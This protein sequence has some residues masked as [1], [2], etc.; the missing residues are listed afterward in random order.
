MGLDRDRMRGAPG[1]T[2]GTGLVSRGAAETA[3]EL[4][5]SS[6]PPS[7]RFRVRPAPHLAALPFLGRPSLI[8]AVTQAVRAALV[9]LAAHRAR[10]VMTMFGIVV[11]VCGVLTINVLGQAQN[12]ALAAQ[13]AQLGTNLISISPGFAA[14]RGVSAGS[15]SKPTLTDRDVQLLQQQVPDVRA[16]TPLVTGTETLAAGDQT[17]GAAVTGAYPSIETV[18]SDA[19]RQ[20]AFFTWADESGRQP[21]AVLGQTVVGHLFPGRSP[22]G[23]NIRIG[24]VDFRVVGVLEPKGH[25]GQ[26][27]LDD[28]AIVPFSTAQERLFGQKVDSIVIQAT[29]TAQIPAV[30]AAATSTLE[31]SHHLPVGGRPDFVVQ[32]F[33]QVVDAAKQQTEL[34]T[35]VLTVVAGVAL[36]IGGF[37]VMN[38]M[39]ISV[40][41]RTAEI[42]LRLA[43]GARPGDVLLQFLVEALTV[44][45]IAGLIGLLLGVAGPVALRPA[46]PLL[47][48]YPA[49]PQPGAALAAFGVVVA[50]GL[51]F[52]FYP[53][54]RASRL[55]PVVAL[56]SE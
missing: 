9:A 37:G 19:V 4:W 49:L 2:D 45:L 25:Q 53:A 26:T 29:Q 36:A 32:D 30:I 13:L 35:R 18:Q 51:I 50:T 41:E 6:S 16:L 10:A 21:V 3:E 1:A 22:L 31:Q 52:G 11:G 44:T 14:L 48:Q 47:A 42:G 7:P 12:A 54:L 28:V 8:A 56:R 5:S 55:D 40:S 43:V 34:L 15:A 24:D 39:L 33:Q 27:D 17:V 38:V 20:G 23:K 46:V